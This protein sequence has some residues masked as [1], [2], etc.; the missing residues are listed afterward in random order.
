MSLP[1]LRGQISAILAAIVMCSLT[2]IGGC[3]GAFESH[4]YGKVTLDGQPIGPGVITFAPDHETAR[5]AVGQIA[6]SGSYRLETGKE[7][8]LPPGHYRVAVQVYKP[9]DHELQP[10]ERVMTPSEPLVPEKFTSVT[11]S[12][13]E[14]DVAP[15]RN[16]IDLHLTS[17]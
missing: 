6:A 1:T 7:V 15:G 5:P 2:M 13:L 11:T 10:G 8:G 16:Q 9:P 4:V 17:E 3:G 12:G 14:Y